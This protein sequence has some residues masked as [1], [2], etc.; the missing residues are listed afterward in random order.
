ME[1]GGEETVW[2]LLLPRRGEK[3]KERKERSISLKTAKA[4][5]LLEKSIG[6]RFIQH[7]GGIIGSF[8]F[9]SKGR[10][11]RRPAET[12]AAP[13]LHPHFSL[14]TRTLR[15]MDAGCVHL[16]RCFLASFYFSFSYLLFTSL[17][18]PL[19]RSSSLASEKSLFCPRFY[20]FSFVGLKAAK[21]R[22]RNEDSDYSTETKQ[23]FSASVAP[24]Y[25]TAPWFF[26]AGEES[27]IFIEEILQIGAI[28]DLSLAWNVSRRRT[29]PFPS[30]F[31]LSLSVVYQGWR[32]N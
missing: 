29:N 21:P 18:F 19:L 26:K 3:N 20:F 11:R 31:S 13:L 10:R 15:R 7:G 24:S 28:Y 14:S 16:P 12:V 5:R 30:P 9:F 17:L 25:L 4:R 22:G 23:G 27:W 8:F 32:F 2:K 1:E 6:R